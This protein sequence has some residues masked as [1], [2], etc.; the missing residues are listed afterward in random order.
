MAIREGKRPDGSLIG[1]PMPF[2]FY[3]QISDEDAKAIVAYLRA[4]SRLPTRSEEYIRVPPAAGLGTARVECRRCH[5]DD[6][7]KYGE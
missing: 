4:S 7:V 1:P 6:P 2:H 5:P 3:S